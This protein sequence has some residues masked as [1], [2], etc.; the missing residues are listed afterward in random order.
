MGKEHHRRTAMKRLY[1]IVEGHTEQEFVNLMIAPYMQQYGVYS[2]T[3]VLI[4][5]SKTGRGGFVNYNY[6]END[7]RRLLY[8]KNTDFVVSMFVD[9]FRIP[10]NLPNKEKWEHMDN[11]LEQIIMM[12]KCIAE[13]INDN[14]FIPYIQMHEF[15]ALLFSSNK[16]FDA[17]FTEEESKN[18]LRIIDTYCNPEDINTSPQ[19]APSK[20]LLAIKSNYDK[21]IEGNLIALEIGIS[22]IIAKCPRFRSWIEKL[23]EA[24][25]Q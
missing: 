18:T 7:V 19:G 8:S 6:L 17:Y 25:K 21:V 20:R 11:H 14:R 2:V 1:I 9:Y 3:P 12:E 22:D 5:T 10:N 16:G 23:I 15:E 4:R 24:C 13:E